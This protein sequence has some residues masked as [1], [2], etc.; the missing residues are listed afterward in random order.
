MQCVFF[1]ELTI[2]VKLHTLRSNLLVLVRSVVTVL[3]FST[4]QS[5]TISHKAPPERI[6]TK[7]WIGALSISHREN[8]I[9][10]ICDCQQFEKKI[11]RSLPFTLSM[12]KTH[13]KEKKQ[14]PNPYACHRRMILRNRIKGFI[15]INSVG[16]P[17]KHLNH[18]PKTK[19][20]KI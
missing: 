12:I 15:H 8:H 18:S 9:M 20:E 5:N 2:F 4:S 19:D 10:K 11:A 7:K 16:I 17:R 3:A 14:N 13:H 1:T 6:G